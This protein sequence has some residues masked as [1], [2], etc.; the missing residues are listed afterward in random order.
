MISLIEKRVI[1]NITFQLYA[2]ELKQF[3]IGV[4]EKTIL[5]LF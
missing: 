5:F 4:N 2:N 1:F 3:Y